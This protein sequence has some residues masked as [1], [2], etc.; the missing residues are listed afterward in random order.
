MSSGSSSASVSDECC[1]PAPDCDPCED[2]LDFFCD[3]VPVTLNSCD[4][5]TEFVKARYRSVKMTAANPQAGVHPMDRIFELSMAENDVTVS[6]GGTVTEA[7]GTVWTIYAI[8]DIS[9]FCLK[10]IWARSV[11]ACFGLLGDIDVFEEDCRCDDGCGTRMLYKRVA[12]SKGNILAISGVSLARNDSNDL[13]Y[14]FSCDLA[15]WP[16]RELPGSKHRLKSSGRTYRIS[17]VEDRGVFVPFHMELE[18]DSEPC[19]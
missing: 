10:R 2:W 7:D 12:R 16:L 19:C 14:R 3:F 18:V 5:E 1:F 6:A 11:S 13:V 4:V 15:R 8:E 9:T 17:R